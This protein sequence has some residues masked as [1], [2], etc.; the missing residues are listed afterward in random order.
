MDSVFQSHS[1]EVDSGLQ[2]LVGFRIPSDGLQ[3][4]NPVIPDPQANFFCGFW[5]LQAKVFGIPESEFPFMGRVLSSAS[6]P[7]LNHSKTKS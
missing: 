6:Q 1:V 3:I 4:P 5:I 2:T 7:D